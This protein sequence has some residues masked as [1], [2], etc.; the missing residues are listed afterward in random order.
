MASL[1]F[2]SPPSSLLFSPSV[3]NRPRNL[4][5]FITSSSTG[6]SELM[7]KSAVGEPT[8]RSRTS[9][10]LKNLTEIFWV[11]VHSAEGRPLNVGLREPVTIGCST[12]EKV[13]NMAVRVE[14]SNGCV[15]WGEVP[16]VPGV[17]WNQT[18]ALE[19]VGKA[20]EFLSQGPPVTLNL[21]LHQISEMFPATQFAPVRAGLEMALIDAVANSID[22]PLW[23]LF[24]GVSN[25]LTCAA[26]IP[27]TSSAKAFDLAAEYFKLGFKTLVIKLGRN[28]SSDIEV[29]QAVRAAHPH[30]LF[31]LDANEGYTSKEAVEVLDKL[32][33]IGVTPIL[34]EQPVHRD[35][36]RGLGDVSNVA[37][38]KYG[39]SVAADE[40]CRDLIDIQ[41]L[42]EG[43]L[44]DVINLKLSKFGVLGILEIVEMVKKSGLELV[45][46]SVAETR[47]ATGV[48]G[49]LAA[50]LG[51]FKYV[52]ISAPL[53][54]SED[55]VVGGYEVSGS[56]YKF[57][58]SR[59]QGGFLK[60]DFLS[61]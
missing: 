36:W 17:N 21:V 11:D 42:M 15:G 10:G 3:V 57:V 31:I 6:S 30:C 1:G 9:L 8:E 2:C 60:W 61:W 4:Q 45:I 32:N 59:G 26:T 25:S 51:C 52:N 54:L 18:T 37:R 28:L 34:F 20:C 46:D 24:G 23:R 47:L 33:E 22:V 12:L 55:P 29:L 19:K 40:S 41:K 58:N 56:E 7:T 27:T 13:E 16:V 38:H 14:L 50:G 39:I 43:N 44:V 53:L 48:A 5:G 35:D 49:H